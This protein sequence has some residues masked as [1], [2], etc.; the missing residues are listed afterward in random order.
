MLWTYLSAQPVRDTQTQVVRTE[1]SASARKAAATEG[2]AALARFETKVAKLPA[3]RTATVELRFATVTLTPKKGRRRPVL[4]EAIALREVDPPEGV[5]PLDGILLTTCPVTTVTEA[6]TVVGYYQDRYGI[7]P[8]HRI[9]KSGLHLE[10]EAVADLAS[11][12]RLLAIL[13]P[14]ASHLA[15][16]T[17]AA[18]VTPQA[19][20]AP[21][22]EPEVLKALKDACRFHKLPLPRRAWTLKDVVTR[23]AQLG[24]YEPRP[25]RVPGW[26]VIWRG[27]RELLRF[28]AIFEYAQTRRKQAPD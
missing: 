15:Q 25:D 17:Y 6:R 3:S 20:A 14:T 10:R 28:L 23:L 26:I 7:E 8:F 9:W 16:W 18:R 11:F 5:E 24:G 12:T 22:V 27:W 4:V 13:M 19:P 2:D 1:V 21:H